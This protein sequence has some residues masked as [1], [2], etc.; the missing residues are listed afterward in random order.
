[1]RTPS[2]VL[3]LFAACNA[4]EPVCPPTQLPATTP[5]PAPEPALVHELDRTGGLRLVFSV[6]GDDGE[7]PERVAAAFRQRIAKSFADNARVYRLD[8]NGV[9]V[10]LPPGPE[11]AAFRALLRELKAPVPPFEV[12]FDVQRTFGPSMPSGN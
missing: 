5:E 4:P 8:D 11:P 10:D 2:L 6:V 7:A 1:M 12:R 3:L 9:V